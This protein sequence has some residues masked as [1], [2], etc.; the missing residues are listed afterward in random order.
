MAWWFAALL[1]MDGSL[2]IQNKE[3]KWDNQAKKE[4]EIPSYSEWQLYV[5]VVSFHMVEPK[6]MGISN[7]HIPLRTHAYINGTEWKFVGIL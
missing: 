2:V 6:E 1:C 7:I 3:H 5:E 4:E